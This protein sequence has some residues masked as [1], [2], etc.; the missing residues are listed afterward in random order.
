MFTPCVVFARTSTPAVSSRVAWPM[1]RSPSLSRQV[2]RLLR[3]GRSGWPGNRDE[4]RAVPGLVKRLRE[5]GHVGAEH[6]SVLR[7]DV[8][9]SRKVGLGEMEVDLAAVVACGAAVADQPDGKSGILD[10]QPREFALDT[11]VSWLLASLLGG[12]HRSS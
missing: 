9:E 3:A 2:V 10:D 7:V 12:D 1:R 6:G 11:L 4:L 5:R 8:V